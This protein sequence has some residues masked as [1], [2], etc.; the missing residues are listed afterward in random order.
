MFKS[1]I[2]KIGSNV[3]TQ[4]DG[5]L[6]LKRVAHLVDQIAELHAKNKKVILVSSGAVAAGRSM[7]QVDKKAD[8]VSSRQLLSSVGQVKLISTY[9]KLFQKHGMQCAQV[10]VTKQDFRSREHYLNMKNCVTTLCDNGIIPIIN[11][12][13]AVSVTALMFTDN[14]ELAGLLA[15]MMG[16]DALFILSNVNGIY[17]GDPDDVQSQVIRTIG[18]STADLSQY[19]S[20]TKSDFGRGGMLTK[21]RI[22]QKTAAS[23]TSVHIANGTKQNILLELNADADQVEHTQFIKGVKYKAV[24]KWIAYSESFTNAE[25]HINAGAFEALNSKKATS[26]LLAGVVKMTGDFKKGDLLKIILENGK[27]VGIGKAQYDRARA[28]K[29]IHDIKYKPLIHYDYLYLFA[30]IE[31]TV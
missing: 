20:T 6:H 25:V 3:L 8:T 31:V 2:I 28:E 22:A 7:V 16:S 4:K 27:T 1:I 17:N 14:D 5:T 9:S 23:G 19:I 10:L 26:L 11:E 13:D 12:N 21:C 29:H 24:K 15:T 30:D 18:N